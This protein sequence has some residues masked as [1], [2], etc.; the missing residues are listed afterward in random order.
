[1]PGL[2]PIP[3]SGNEV[4]PREHYAHQASESEHSDEIPGVPTQEPPQNFH[5]LTPNKEG[6]GYFPG[7]WFTCLVIA[8]SS[9]AQ[10]PV[11]GFVERS[12]REGAERG[13]P[14]LRRYVAA[15][16]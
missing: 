9:A 16:H 12:H 5:Q 8:V 11:L 1:V 2:P 6:R 3:P 15:W 4:R 13:K 10:P 7:P 14:G